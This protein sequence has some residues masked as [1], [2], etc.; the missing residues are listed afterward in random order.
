MRCL[1]KNLSYVLLASLP[2]FVGCG[3]KSDIS[4]H[5]NDVIVQE[6]SQLE[7]QVQPVMVNDIVD[8]E[9]KSVQKEIS[10]DG[11][12][13]SIWCHN[14]SK[15]EK[16]EFKYDVVDHHVY[17]GVVKDNGRQA[18][19]NAVVSRLNVTSWL[20]DVKNCTLEMQSGE[21]IY[22]ERGNIVTPLPYPIFTEEDNWKRTHFAEEKVLWYLQKF[23][24]EVKTAVDKLQ[25]RYTD[26]E[27]DFKRIE[28]F[29]E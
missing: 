12:T 13:L 27:R 14:Q 6:I 16:V 11:R 26:A 1:A 29:L 18:K 25:D 15:Q 4:Q 22:A 8:E 20:V 23:D 24:R 2:Y 10:H 17:L 5:V 3:K 21:R 19:I 28:D 9:I 7:E